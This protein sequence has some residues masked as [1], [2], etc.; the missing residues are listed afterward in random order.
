MRSH[1]HNIVQYLLLFSLAIFF[2]TLLQLATGRRD[3]QSIIIFSF[4]VSYIFWGIFHHWHDHSLYFKVVL[5]YI[6]IGT[7]IFLLLQNLLP[8]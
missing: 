8:R 2:L 3:V 4:V 7:I 1:H 5:E 6:L